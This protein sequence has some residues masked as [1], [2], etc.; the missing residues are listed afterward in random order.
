MGL[1]LL[2]AKIF[3]LEVNGL[4]DKKLDVLK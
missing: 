2:Q 4:T 1:V 3:I